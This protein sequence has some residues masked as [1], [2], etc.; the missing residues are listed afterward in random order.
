MTFKKTL[1]YHNNSSNK[2]LENIGL[3][4]QYMVLNYGTDQTGY[5]Y[6]SLRVKKKRYRISNA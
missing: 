2:I 3:N 1:Q 4:H 6:I 5:K